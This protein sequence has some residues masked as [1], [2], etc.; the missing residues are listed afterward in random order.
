MMKI[1][2][3]KLKQKLFLVQSSTL[4]ETKSLIVVEI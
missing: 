4:F 1:T 2:I 3:A